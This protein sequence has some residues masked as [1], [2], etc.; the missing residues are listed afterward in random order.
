MRLSRT[1][2]EARLL[3]ADHGV[4][5]TLHP[6]RLID[7]VPVCFT[8]LDR[9]VFIPIDLVKPKSS[10]YLQRVA[11]LAREPRATLLCETWSR[12]DWSRLAWVRANL[13]WLEDTSTEHDVLGHGE[14]L[15]REKYPQYR[16]ARFA[17]IL[18]FVIEG[19]DGWSAS[20]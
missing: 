11:N 20:T 17:A 12:H 4:F 5:S 8:V 14:S 16:S 3:V 9:H 6:E 18:L 7:S 13:A 2:C 10:S 15:L 19:I 1:E